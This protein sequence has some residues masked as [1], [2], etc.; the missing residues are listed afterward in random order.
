[1]S[2]Q[3]NSVVT[4]VIIALIIATTLPLG[5][6]G[7][8]YYTNER[9]QQLAALQS[10]LAINTD[11]LAA[12][13][14][15]PAWNYDD[16]QIDKISEGILND[17]HIYGVVA[18][19]NGK[20]YVR[21]RDARWGIKAADKEFPTKGLIVEE[22]KITLS[23]NS[24]GSVKVFAT[25]KFIK[26]QLERTLVFIVAIIIFVDFILIL[27][28]YLVIWCIMLNPL[29]KIEQYALA[30]SSGEG[31]G[32]TIQDSGFH[33]ELESLRG[34]IEKMVG[35]LDA[36]YAEL[37]MSA[38][39]LRKSEEFLYNIVENIPN[40][41]FVKDAAD[42]RFV[43]FNR[44]GEKLLG[45]TREELLGKNDYDFFPKHE[46]D[47]F[48]AKDRDVFSLKHLVNV[49][50][51]LIQTRNMGERVLHTMKMPVFDNK[52]NP[53]YL[54]G[55]S[56]DITE[57]KR[58]EQEIRRLNGE[59][60]QKMEQLQEAQEELVR[61]EK[62]AILGRLA[63]IVGHE[64]R[65][66]L[67][68]MNNAVYYLKMVLTEADETTKEYLDIIRQ[69]IGNSL[70][71]IS[72]LLDFARTRTPQRR[73]ITVRELI[74]GN[75]GKCTTP[76]NIS[77]QIDI[78]GTLPVVNVDPPQMG[79]VFQNLITNAVQAMPNGGVLTISA[80]LVQ[81]S[82]FEVSGS[83]STLNTQHSTLDADFIEIRIED[84]GEGITPEN[85]PKL[86]Q[87]LFTTKIKGVGLGLVVCKNLIEA[88][89]GRI[90]VES[91]F[92]KGTIFSV[93]LPFS[94]RGSE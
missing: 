38:Q 30:V 47:F 61:K 58:D 57:R 27:S 21:Q 51:E 93:I 79:Q 86:F 65:N 24:L 60:L 82:T 75:L 68:V 64:L 40:M 39:E 41:I 32:V 8:I 73:T 49:S 34:S 71:I 28:L 13:L 59:L 10:T 29:K 11:R 92:N 15:I 63:G 2:F 83:S 26:E 44:A 94:E 48:T 53:Q 84:T 4:I 55:I 1:M 19:V 80:R 54:L 9:H 23:N 31:E 5:A 69:E 91:M 12:D 50:E 42:L 6:V 7:I 36:R 46:A 43:K 56:E 72:D 37:N 70:R 20:I 62:L 33:G 74:D 52:G 66:P 67:G 22:R 17:R 45:Y 16:G 78:P 35:L 3:K 14:A 77:V 89:G 87:P 18:N 88:N 25:T 76:E 90:K 85:L 81:R